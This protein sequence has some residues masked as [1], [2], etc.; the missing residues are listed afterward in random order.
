MDFWNELHDATE[1]VR[2]GKPSQGEPSEMDNLPDHVKQFIGGQQ[3][4]NTGNSGVNN[5][6]LDRDPAF[7]NL[8]DH[9]KNNPFANLS[10]QELMELY[11][12]M[13]KDPQKYN[14]STQNIDKELAEKAAKDGKPY[15]DPEGG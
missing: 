14:S 13:M 6:N 4:S 3:P 5:R 10:K 15:I 2:I 11:E 12:K 1:S 9:L 7:R 8:P